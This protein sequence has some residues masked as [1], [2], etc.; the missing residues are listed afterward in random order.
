MPGRHTRSPR[1]PKYRLHKASGQ[2][3]VTLSGRDIYLGKHGSE[4]SN[5]RYHE[6]IARWQLQ[7]GTATHCALR[8]DK[9]TGQ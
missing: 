9:V 2:A 4:E 7:Q 1:I 6:E 3:V 5:A 8:R